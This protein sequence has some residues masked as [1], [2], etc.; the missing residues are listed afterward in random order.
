MRLFTKRKK[1]HRADDWH[2]DLFLRVFDMVK[3]LDRPDYK[4][5][6][7][8]INDAYDGFQKVR[9]VQTRDDR[10]SAEINKI[11]EEIVI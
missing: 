4:N 8:G 1:Q 5:L 10:E 3:D 2:E 11:E 6:I 7:A 9:K